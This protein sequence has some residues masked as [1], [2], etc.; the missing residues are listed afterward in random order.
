MTIT[1]FNR[2]I[3]EMELHGDCAQCN[4]RPIEIVMNGYAADNSDI[5]VCKECATQLARKLLE[6]ICDLNGDRHG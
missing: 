5:Q 3:P 1:Q 4:K 2:A 6:D